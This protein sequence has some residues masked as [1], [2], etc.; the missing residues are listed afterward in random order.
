MIIVKTPGKIRTAAAPTA[1]FKI[2]QIPGRAA[3]PAT[4]LKIMSL[5]VIFYPEQLLI[6]KTGL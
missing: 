6:I 2:R 3:K 5:K 4:S 1:A